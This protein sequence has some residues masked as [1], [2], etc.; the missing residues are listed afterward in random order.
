MPS[1]YVALTEIP[2]ENAASQNAPIFFTGGKSTGVAVNP[3]ALKTTAEK[4]IASAKK[5]IGVPYVWGGMTP[6]GFDCSGLVQYVFAEN[7][8]NVPRTTA[9]QYKIG[10]S[11]SKSNLKPGDLVFFKNTYDAGRTVTHVGI[12]VGNNM[13]LHCGDPI[14]YES[15]TK[16]YWQEHFYAYGRLP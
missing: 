3:A 7:G 2:Y 16:S 14:Q 1:D 12:Y 4:I 13:M 15:L 11:V 9:L 8:V 10:T 6:S 5:H